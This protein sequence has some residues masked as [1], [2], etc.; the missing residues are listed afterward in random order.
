MTLVDGDLIADLEAR[1]LIHDSTDR[2]HLRAQVAAGPIGIYYGCDPTADSLH[3]GNLIG[4]VMLRRF[5]DAGHK[6]VALAGGAT[7][8]IGDPSGKSEERNLLDDDALNHNVDCI[9]EQ[10]GRIVD[11][12]DPQRGTLVD[13]RD[14]TQPI[15]ILEFLR[16]VGKHVTVNQMLARESVKTRLNSEHGISFTEFSYML[17][18]ANDYLH[19]YDTEGCVIQIGGSDQWGNIVSGV[20]F[21]RRKRQAAVHGFSWPLLTAADGSKLGKTSGARVWL[22]SAKTS[23]YA[24][25][26]HWMQTPDDIV[27]TQLLMFSL[28]PV[29]EIEELVERHAAEPHRRIGQ[30]ALADDMV[31]LVHGAD[32]AV[33]ANEAADVLFASDPTGASAAAFE[34]LS[35]EIPHTRMNA[36]E[37]E[38]SINVLVATDLAKSNGDARRTMDQN[39][40]SANGTRL[41]AKDQLSDQKLLHGKY[42]LLRRGKKV[43]HLVEIIS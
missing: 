35:R 13:N 6:A 36:R 26:Q 24:F 3:V 31:T 40:Y 4:L 2:E 11:L 38:D 43:H 41:T 30:R 1:G 22:D 15:T 8:M 42:L 20:D 37:L 39:S 25:R 23:A 18:Q 7:G 32:A 16:D 34:I 14:W 5:Q 10:L 28:R 12:D 19:L 17:L 29:A 33:A 27:R 21:I 9:K